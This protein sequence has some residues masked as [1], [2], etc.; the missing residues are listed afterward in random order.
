LRRRGGGGLRMEENIRGVAHMRASYGVHDPITATLILVGCR[1]VVEHSV[2]ARRCKWLFC[3]VVVQ[4][5]EGPWLGG[6]GECMMVHRAQ[7]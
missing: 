1:R 6:C 3:R 7:T 2:E 5:D 4:I